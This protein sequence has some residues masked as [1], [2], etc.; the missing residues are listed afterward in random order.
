MSILSQEIN[1]FFT[2]DLSEKN[3]N[4]NNMP[5]DESN[6]NDKKEPDSS[7]SS[8]DL[9]KINYFAILSDNENL[10]QNFLNDN[11]FPIE[12]VG[13]HYAPEIDEPMKIKDVVKS[14]LYLGISN[15]GVMQVKEKKTFLYF[16]VQKKLMDEYTFI[17]LF[18]ICELIPGATLIQILLCVYY[19]KTK[20]FWIA[21]LGIFLFLLPGI[22]CLTVTFLLISKFIDRFYEY[23]FFLIIET[24]VAQSGLALLLNFLT[25]QFIKLLN[26]NFQSGIVIITVGTLLVKDTLLIML[27]LF[28]IMGYLSMKK[29]EQQ[30]SVH[31]LDDTIN[32]AIRYTSSNYRYIAILIYLLCF[33]AICF[34]SYVLWLDPNNLLFKFYTMGSLIFMDYSTINFLDSYLNFTIQKIIISFGFICLFQGHVFNLLI[35]LM[36]DRGL[37]RMLIYLFVLYFPSILLGYI[38]FKAIHKINYNKELQLFLKGMRT[39]SLGFIFSI[40]PSLW[41]CTCLENKYYHWVFGTLI[42]LHGWYWFYKRKFLIGSL[43]TILSSVLI[44]IISNNFS[45]KSNNN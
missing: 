21:L 12:L 10:K 44:A 27:L 33:L 15:F 31:Y 36:M 4:N 37:I 20:S 40:V 14:A 16:V 42:V 1:E 7:R 18:S 43:I 19:I 6:N 22:F 30:A 23:K 35:V 29:S 32:T 8:L 34:I 5:N 26:S 28:C 13:Q 45:S 3:K 38:A 2:E 25:F 41:Q 17:K 11:L 24:G 39:T 9:E